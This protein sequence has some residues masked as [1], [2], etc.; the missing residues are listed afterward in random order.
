MLITKSVTMVL[1]V[2]VGTVVIR[3]AQIE[4]ISLGGRVASS[5]GVEAVALLP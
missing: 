2:A 5:L 3:Y 4:L 1:V